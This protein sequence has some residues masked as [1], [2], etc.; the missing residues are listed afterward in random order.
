MATS[1]F[2]HMDYQRDDFV[3]TLLAANE[4][5]LQGQDAAKGTPRVKYS[6]FPSTNNLHEKQFEKASVEQI[7]RVATACSGESEGG[8]GGGGRQ[9][10]GLERGLKSR[11]AQM[12]ALVRSRVP[13]SPKSC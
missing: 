7:S 13:T 9:Q 6:P 8:G 10:Q 1:P 2:P 11:H 5:R 3:D 12:I 4:R